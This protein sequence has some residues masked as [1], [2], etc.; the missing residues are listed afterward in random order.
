MTDVSFVVPSR[1]H[2]AL[3][4]RLTAGLRETVAAGGASAELIVVDNGSADPETLAWLAALES[5]V[6]P[7]ERA[8]VLRAPGPFNYPALNNAGVARA[9]GEHLC[10]L[11]DDVETLDVHW[12]EALLHEARA[13]DVGCVGAL[14]RYPD[15]TVQHAGVALGLG[16]IA[17]HVYKHAPPGEPGHDGYLRRAQRVTAV[18]GACLLLRRALYLELGGLDERLA[19]SW[20]DVDLCLRAR[21]AGLGNVW[22]PDAVLRHH[23]SK[24]RG[25]SGE[26]SA[27]QRRQH[28]REN[29]Y[30]RRK[31][32]GA[33]VSDPCLAGRL[34]DEVL[35][36]AVVAPA[37][38]W[39]GWM[40]RG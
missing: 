15:D 3:L 9:R 4:S 35:G 37:R 28:K 6:A 14:L 38:R 13:P 19:V 25:R 36:E 32:P 30:M 11:N 40:R 7:F 26:R 10:L 5:D 33:F 27:A 34:P 1:D 39:S 22:T 24:S 21:A 16:G 31:W 18:T 20:N 17:G 23:E 8:L 12:L 2:R 29:R